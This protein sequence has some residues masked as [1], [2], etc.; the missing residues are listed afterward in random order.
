MKKQRI[1]ERF[2]KQQLTEMKTKRQQLI[3]LCNKSAVCETTNEDT[4]SKNLPPENVFEPRCHEKSRF[5]V[6]HY[7]L[8]V[9]VEIH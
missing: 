6:Y 9:G 8:L 1:L 3:S 7:L 5:Q 4:S 2:L